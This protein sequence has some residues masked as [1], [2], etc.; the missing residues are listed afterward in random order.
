MDVNAA[1]L[2]SLSAWHELE[3]GIDRWASVGALALGGF[4]CV[5]FFVLR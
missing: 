4:A 3:Q 1:F 5:L 2:S